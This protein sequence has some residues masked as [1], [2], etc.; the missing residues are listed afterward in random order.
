MSE[1]YVVVFFLWELGFPIEAL[2][3]RVLET[4]VLQ[5]V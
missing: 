1:R 5:S 3:V 4:T 2:F